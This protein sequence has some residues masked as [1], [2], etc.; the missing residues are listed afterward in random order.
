[1]ACGYLIDTQ[2][3]SGIALIAAVMA[4]SIRAVMENR[5]PAARTALTTLWL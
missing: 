5:A 1:M 4:G 3:C 2:A